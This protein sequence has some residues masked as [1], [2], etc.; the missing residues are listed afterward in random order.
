GVA[1]PAL[2]TNA[3]QGTA[4]PV[5]QAAEQLKVDHV[6]PR[7]G[8][9]HV[10]QLAFE[11]GGPTDQAQFA[12]GQLAT[13]ASVAGV[14][15]HDVPTRAMNASVINGLLIGWNLTL[16][17]VQAR[18]AKENKAPQC[19]GNQP[20]RAIVAGRLFSTSGGRGARETT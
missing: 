3:L 12:L 13:A 6:T 15:G 1:R 19:R 18:N 7:H 2:E 17:Q 14:A 9:L 16:D 20:P 11:R 8:G 5:G 10:L 4:Q